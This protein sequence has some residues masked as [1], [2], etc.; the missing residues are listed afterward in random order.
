[1]VQPPRGCLRASPGHHPDPLTGAAAGS[2]SSSGTTNVAVFGVPAGNS[3]A[4][5]PVEAGQAVIGESVAKDL[6]LGVGDT[7]S[8]AGVD[9]Q[10]GSIVA[11][12]WYSHTSVVYTDLDSWT[13]LAHLGNPT[14]AGT[15]IAV[16]N[17]EGATV[18]VDAANAAAATSAPP[19]PDPMRHWA[20]TRA[21]TARC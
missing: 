13:K 14:Q 21:K 17:Q 16:A 2:A 7:V 6:S 12:N 11:D 4:P 1:M 8:M 5:A 18:D 20:P 10:V 3:L 9:L 15:V 19:A